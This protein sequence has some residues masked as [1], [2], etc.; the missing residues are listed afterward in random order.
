MKIPKTLKIGGINYLVV[1]EPIKMHGAS[2]CGSCNNAVAV[3]TINSE[4]NNQIQETT[5]IHE[6]IEAINSINDLQL[7]HQTISTLETN[8]FQVLR[9]ND[10]LK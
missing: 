10:L 2:N 9:D 6:I 4:D 1:V 7:S 3:I 5:L 8:L